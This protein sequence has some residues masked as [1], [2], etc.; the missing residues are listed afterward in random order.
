M[1]DSYQML[2][3]EM[4]IDILLVQSLSNGCGNWT[5]YYVWS[6]SEM[7]TF[8]AFNIL[9]DSVSVAY[10]VSPWATKISV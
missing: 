7:F 6:I 4:A 5:M 3:A 8:I 9:P 1:H 2:E 10:I